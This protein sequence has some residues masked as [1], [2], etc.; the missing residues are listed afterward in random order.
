MTPGINIIQ[1]ID[2]PSISRIRKM[3]IIIVACLRSRVNAVASVN[4]LCSKTT[5]NN[6]LRKK[7]YNNYLLVF[8]FNL[9]STVIIGWK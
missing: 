2:K 7:L 4:V 3:S 6:L 8:I 5:Q 9:L 1:L